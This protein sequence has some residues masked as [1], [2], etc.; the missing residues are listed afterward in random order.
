MHFV[1]G[2]GERRGIEVQLSDK[3]FLTQKGASTEVLI[4]QLN[5]SMRC[6]NVYLFRN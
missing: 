6:H 4:F 1:F 2:W 3:L 5:M